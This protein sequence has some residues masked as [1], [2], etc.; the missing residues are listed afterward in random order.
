M[1]FAG[2]AALLAA[3][4]SC[5]PEGAGDWI[6]PQYA[7][8]L[9]FVRAAPSTP[10]DVWR[11]GGDALRLPSAQSQAVLHEKIGNKNLVM[12][13]MWPG[14][15]LAEL[16]QNDPRTLAFFRREAGQT[17][18]ALVA[19]A[20]DMVGDGL[21]AAA[22]AAAGHMCGAVTPVALAG[23]TPP[24]ETLTPA[25]YPE[26]APLEAVSSMLAQVDQ[27]RLGAIIE[28]LEGL[29]TRFHSSESGLATT[30]KVKE[31]FQ[32]AAALEAAGAVF[33]EVDHSATTLTQPT[34]QKSLVLTL[35]GQT[36]DATTVVVGAH[37]DSINNASPQAPGAD[38]DAS[39]VAT[40]VEMA[41]VIAASGAKF[42]RR[43]ELHAYAGEEIALIGSRHIASSYRQ[44][45]RKV[46]A[47]MQV[48]MNS[49]SRD[50]AQQT[51]HLVTN[52]THVN[53]RR[54]TKDLLNSYL[55]GD[56]VEKRL[57][58]G[59]SDHRSWSDEGY[60][61][62]FPFEDP[63]DY[64]HALHTANDTSATANNL[65]LTKRFAQLGL[66]FL[67]H[68]AG[69]VDGSADAAKTA[70]RAALPSDLKLAVTATEGQAGWYDVSVAVPDAVAAVDFCVIDAA[71][72]LGCTKERIGA[73]AGKTEAGRKFF[74]PKK[75]LALDAGA[76]LAVFG[77]DAGDRLVAYRTVRLGAKP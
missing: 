43:I 47:M 73:T 3:L 64:N 7:T 8:H 75:S 29:G 31:L 12:V 11:S 59:T 62:V 67:A 4:G 35:P 6:R 13:S 16:L 45:G 14:S 25:L 40:L 34:K 52:D 69:L 1:R 68:H 39:G 44:E 30:A 61:A 36:D 5:G 9:S 58:A 63:D 55:G 48:D 57:A 37:L 71:E 60:A 54:S 2:L 10:L 27:A 46:S 77:F 72:S 70:L 24:V 22:H 38:D 74:T 51:I 19:V 56:F 42:H 76:R 28:E 32:S 18:L 49:W 53:L 66:A 26:P 23:M 21:A 65:A 41:R 20:D 17:S 50:P 33:R 15:E